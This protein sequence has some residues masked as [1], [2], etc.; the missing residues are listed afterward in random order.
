MD[1]PIRHSSRLCLII[2]LMIAGLLLA[3]Y[4]VMKTAEPTGKAAHPYASIFQR[5]AHGGGDEAFRRPSALSAS[6]IAKANTAPASL[7]LFRTRKA[8][9]ALFDLCPLTCPAVQIHEVLRL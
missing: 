2:P 1:I 3:A 4:G 7:R 6:T 9:P 5:P 8:S